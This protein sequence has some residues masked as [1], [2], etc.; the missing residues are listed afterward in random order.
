MCSRRS[1]KIRRCGARSRLY[2]PVTGVGAFYVNSWQ[3]S[4][5][6]VRTR[7]ARI[8][9]PS[10]VSA[11][12]S[13]M[14]RPRGGNILGCFEDQYVLPP[15]HH[16]KADRSSVPKSSCPYHRDIADGR[17][18][19]RSIRSI[20]Y[21]RGAMTSV[22]GRPDFPGILSVVRQDLADPLLRS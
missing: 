19:Y 1:D 4:T 6:S 17:N 10:T 8:F 18:S 9:Y 3:V 7:T 22:S 5:Q 2:R 14:A 13:S 11:G 12:M 21:C 15:L 20:G 16:C